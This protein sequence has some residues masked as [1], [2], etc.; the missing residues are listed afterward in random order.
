MKYGGLRRTGFERL[1]NDHA[2]FS[3]LLIG[4]TFA[5]FLMMP[6]P[7]MFAGMSCKSPT[8][9]SSPTRVLHGGLAHRRPGDDGDT[10]Q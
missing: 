9:I 8:G 2:R 1:V 5:V 6:M 7:A 4:I 10:V 3:A